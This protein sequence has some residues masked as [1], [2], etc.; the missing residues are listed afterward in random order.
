MKILMRLGKV[1]SE[2]YS[3]DEALRRNYIGHNTGNL[4]FQYSAYKMFA[5]GCNEI[6]SY[7]YKADK[8]DAAYINENYD[9]FVL[10]LA[11]AFRSSFVNPLLRYSDLIERF[12][13]P[14]LVLGVGA[15]ANVGGG[16]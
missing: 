5:G 13:I 16:G 4:V 8:E 12:R 1:P 10:P 7:G 6:V 9:V 11:N 2:I 15:Q 14:V 3:Y